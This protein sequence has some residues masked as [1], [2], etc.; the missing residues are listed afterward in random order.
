MPNY[1]AQLFLGCLVDATD[2]FELRC[3]TVDAY[4]AN[5]SGTTALK[6]LTEAGTTRMCRKIGDIF[7]QPENGWEDR[8]Y[9]ANI[10]SVVN[11]KSLSLEY[12]AY[13]TYL[14]AFDHKIHGVIEQYCCVC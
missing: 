11:R 12:Q 8:V 4:L 1:L 13:T 7:E 2:L 3:L 10:S 5:D 14:L 6:Y 9:T